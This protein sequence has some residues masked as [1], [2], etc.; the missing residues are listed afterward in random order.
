MAS[1]VGD[2]DP[3]ARTSRQEVEKRIVSWEGSGPGSALKSQ[4]EASQSNASVLDDE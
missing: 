3:E 1:N 2:I 4:E